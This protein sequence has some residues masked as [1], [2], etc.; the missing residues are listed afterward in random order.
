V[1]LGGAG[2]DEGERRRAPCAS[3]GGGPGTATWGSPVRLSSMT[4]LCEMR[5]MAIFGDARAGLMR[6]FARSDWERGQSFVEYTLILAIVVAATVAVLGMVSSAVSGQIDSVTT[7]LGGES[8][9]SAFGV[10][11]GLPSG[12]A[13]A[14]LVVGAVGLYVLRMRRG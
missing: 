9:D 1:R 5:G 13:I 14:V 11:V 10:L 7:A 6:L 8:E 12:I 4:K 2:V 3:V